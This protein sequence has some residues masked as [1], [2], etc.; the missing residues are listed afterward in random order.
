[1]LLFR[2]FF[3]KYCIKKQMLEKSIEFSKKNEDNK[4]DFF[5]IVR[6]QI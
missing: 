3:S 1:M 4:I 6:I 2:V 5:H